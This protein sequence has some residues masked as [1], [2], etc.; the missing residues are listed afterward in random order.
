MNI[1]YPSE[2]N[3]AEHAFL[4]NA[5]LKPPL[6]LVKK[7]LRSDQEYD[8][9]SIPE[10]SALNVI[11]SISERFDGYVYSVI[12]N[13]DLVKVDSF[14]AKKGILP[15]QSGVK[16][17]QQRKISIT[18]PQ[19]VERQGVVASLQGFDYT[20]KDK[21][22]L[23]FVNCLFVLSKQDI[24]AVFPTILSWFSGNIS[25]S[26]AFNCQRAVKT[27]QWRANENQPL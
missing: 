26:F 19:G 5:E 25:S 18:L 13:Q 11:K 1:I 20:V 10:K 21:L 24:D 27:S 8:N 3:R 14:R 4:F 17:L 23:N 6:I 7:L 12:S 16:S 2:F 9:D 15:P 22:V